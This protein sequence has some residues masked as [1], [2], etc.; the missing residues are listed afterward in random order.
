MISSGLAHAMSGS[1]FCCILSSIAFGEVHV[2]FRC[3]RTDQNH[4]KTVSSP[5]HNYFSMPAS[6]NH[7]FCARLHPYLSMSTSGLIPV[8]H[9][10]FGAWLLMCATDIT[11]GPVLIASLVIVQP[12]IHCC[13]TSQICMLHSRSVQGIPKNTRDC[14]G[15]VTCLIRLRCTSEDQ[16]SQ[17]LQIHCYLKIL[18]ST[19]SRHDTHSCSDPALSNTACTRI[20]WIAAKA[21][22]CRYKRLRNRLCS[23]ESRRLC[24]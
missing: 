17:C 20:T 13:S 18:A 2:S 9:L 6:D 12:T 7:H 10:T 23:R 14:R 22:G 19:L 4:R 16:T 24:D 15:H 21:Y 1:Q 3:R 8:S 11:H 5:G